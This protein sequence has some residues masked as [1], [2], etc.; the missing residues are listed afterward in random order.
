M[1][2]EKL[3]IARKTQTSHPTCPKCEIILTPTETEFGII[4]QCEL[5]GFILGESD[6]DRYVRE[7]KEWSKRH[8]KVAYGK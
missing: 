4:L 3:N 1:S 8:K 2:E 5:C 7:N 6:E